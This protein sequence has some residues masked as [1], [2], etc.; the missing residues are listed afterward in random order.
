MI[1]TIAVY[2]LLFCLLPS[3][4]TSQVLPLSLPHPSQKLLCYVALCPF[5]VWP[6]HLFSSSANGLK[7]CLDVLS[8]LSA[9]LLLLF[10]L[11][12]A[13]FMLMLLLMFMFKSTFLRLD[14]GQFLLPF[15]LLVVVVLSAFLGIERILKQQLARRSHHIDKLAFKRVHFRRRREDVVTDLSEDILSYINSYWVLE[16]V[17]FDIVQ[18]SPCKVFL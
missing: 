11:L 9:T 1:Y 12:V 3:L 16:V 18:G 13:T 14:G 2:F 17:S 6:F 5:L 10:I 8:S 15:V 4:L 7:A